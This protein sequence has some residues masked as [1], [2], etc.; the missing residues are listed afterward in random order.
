MKKVLCVPSLYYQKKIP[1]LLTILVS[2]LSLWGLTSAAYA[3]TI[4]NSITASGACFTS[5]SFVLPRNLFDSEDG[6][7]F[8][9]KPYYSTTGVN[10]TTVGSGSV[11]GSGDVFIYYDPALPTVGAAWLVT[12]SGQPYLYQSANASS[13]LP[14]S[15]GWV[16]FTN[17]A[18]L[19]TCSGE[20]PFTIDYGSTSTPTITAGTATGSI[21]ACA[22][23]ASVSPAVQSFV[24][25]GSSLTGNIVANAP[26]G[27]QISTNV[28]TGYASSLTL[29]QT[30]GSVANT[31]VYVRSSAS[32]TGSIS[33]NVSLTSTG[34]TAR[35]VAVTGTVTALPNVSISPTSPTITQGTTGTLTAS[36]ANSFV[37]SAN[38]GSAT[39]TSVTVNTANTYSVTGTTDGCSR[40]ASAVVSVTQASASGL[41]LTPVASPATICAGSPVSLSVGVSGGSSPYSYTWAAPGGVNISGQ[42]N[43]SAITA[44]LSSSGVQTFTVTVAASGGSPSSSST[45]SVTVNA[46]PSVSIT[47][48]SG[49]TVANSNSLTLTASGATSYSWSTG[50]IGSTL[51][52][53]PTS[54]ST[55]SVTGLGVSGGCSAT[56]SVQVSVTSC[57]ITATVAGSLTLCP[58]GST[59]LIA[60]GAGA[61]GTYQW[62]GGPAS[63]SYVVSSVGS[64]TVRVTSAG[65]CTATAM[66]TVSSGSGPSVHVTVAPSQTICAGSLVALTAVGTAGG[67]SRI[68]TP[69]NPKTGQAM[70]NGVSPITYQ[71]STGANTVSINVAPGSTTVYSVTATNGGCSSAPASVTI[72]VNPLPTVTITFPTSASV[73]PVG[74]VITVPVGQGLGYQ[75]FGGGTN[76]R[77]ER[78]III[79]RIN[80]YEIRTA[81]ENETGTFPI[82]RAGRYS[83]TVT[84]ANGCSRTVTGQIVGQ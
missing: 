51:S 12:I 71:W 75:V 9:G 80:G 48:S 42:Q 67:S 21:T 43:Q 57:N 83:I 8:N 22:G 18:G 56:A 52:F 50:A 38:A 1:A 77:Y 65:N 17:P 78:K 79:D 61:G 39:T 32:A 66:A 31:T 25:S 10:I 59:T 4:P 69:I 26:T 11:S 28:G 23:T 70:Q 45:V 16:A 63:A 6:P 19:G 33:G 58:G 47:S 24:V 46:L 55:I 36:G 62:Q 13:A 44:S 68:A 5:S 73:N 7:L 27:F 35:N 41:S 30:S 60:S 37:W 64:Y 49:L 84:D 72:T 40:T 3:Q 34:A 15:T 76:G 53:T 2:V 82:D 81:M 74:P 29:T 20:N 54:A 14:P